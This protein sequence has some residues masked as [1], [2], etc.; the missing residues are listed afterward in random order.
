M[1]FKEY[2][3]VASKKYK[4]AQ[5]LANLQ[6]QKIKP[7]PVLIEGR[8]IAHK[9]WGKA[10]CANLNTYADYNNRIS[11]GKSYI[12]NGAVVDLKI[13]E[14][15]V[16]ALVCGTRKKPYQ[17]NISMIKISTNRQKEINKYIKQNIENI[18]ELLEGNFAK[19]LKDL[20]IDPNFGLFPTINEIDFTC[21]CPDYA[22]CCKHVSAT[23]YAIGARFDTNPELLFKLRGIK[24]DDLINKIVTQESEKLLN[25]KIVTKRKVVNDK[26]INDLFNLDI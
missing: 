7:D 15:N 6:K 21:N 26:E 4:N 18:G 16:T 25:K 22:T 2:E 13:E 11:R 14:N 19:E 12:S 23:L 24:I 1:R 5:I 8:I 3:S 9:W 10:W 20:F 17:V